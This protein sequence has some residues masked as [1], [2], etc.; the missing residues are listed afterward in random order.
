V[1]EGVGNWNGYGLPFLYATNGEI[2]WF[3]DIQDEKPVSRTISNF[4]TAPA[5]EQLFSADL[6]P[7]RGRLLDTPIE[8]IEHLHDYQR[9]AIGAIESTLLSRKRHLLIAMA[10]GTAKTYMTVAEV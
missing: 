9:N 6:K 1:T 5:L 2:I 3:I 8:R 7:S 10:T 4:H